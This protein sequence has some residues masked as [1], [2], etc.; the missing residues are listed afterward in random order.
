QRM[1]QISMDLALAEAIAILGVALVLGGV[2]KEYEWLILL[3]LILLGFGGLYP[4]RTAYLPAFVCYAVSAVLVLYQTRTFVLMRTVKRGGVPPAVPL[5]KQNWG[6]RAMHLAVVAA[7]TVLLLSNLPMPRGESRGIVPVSFQTKQKLEFPEL[8]KHWVKP[9][10][11]LTGSDGKNQQEVDAGEKPMVLSKR[12]SRLVRTDKAENMDAREGNG[13]NGI[14]TDLVFRVKSP[15]KLYWLAQLYD[16]YDGDKWK[17]SKHLREAGSTL[18]G[19][20]ARNEREIRQQFSIEKNVSPRLYGAYKVKAFSMSADGK[21][22]L[23]DGG[24]AVVGRRL[25]VEN[26]LGG[27]MLNGKLPEPPWTYTAE[28]MVPCIEAETPYA[29]WQSSRRAGWNYRKLPKK[30]ISDR[31]RRLAEDL[32]ADCETAM[33]KANVLRDFL[34]NNFEYTLEPPP[35]PKDKEVVDWFLFETRK[36]YCHHFAQALTVLAR[37]SGLHARLATGYSPGNY[38]LLSN[39]FE[40]YEY[41]A[42]AWVHIFIEPYGWLTYDG[43]PPGELRLDTTPTFF[44]GLMDPFGEEWASHPPELSLPL[45]KPETAKNDTSQ[46]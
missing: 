31:L 17:C 1:T 21:E 32:T 7:L 35:I 15:A 13:G 27:A 37:L 46:S 30:H 20:H 19:F 18:D 24:T 16:V 9:T 23:G 29:P 5:L 22:V 3:S 2:A 42:H 14:G 34:R 41:H 33:E 25:L 36:G 45:K 10:K 12:A 11:F 40:V 38:N 44:H 28:S 8:W 4:G 43:V 26:H 6:Y 39:C